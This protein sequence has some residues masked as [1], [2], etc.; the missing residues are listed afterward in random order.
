[1]G[2]GVTDDGS[3]DCFS[4]RAL[5]HRRSTACGALNKGRELEWAFWYIQFMM[6]TSAPPSRV[7]PS[8]TPN[9]AELA[10]W[11]A[12]SREEQLRRLQAKLSHPDC[13]AVSEATMGDILG[14]ARAA[15]KGRHG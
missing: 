11:E 5:R 7:M 14:H 2:F 4:L 9:E 3:H 6:E 10:A 12:L 8:A 15:A 13:S 1:M